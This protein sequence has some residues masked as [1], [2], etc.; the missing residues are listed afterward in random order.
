MKQSNRVIAISAFLMLAISSTVMQTVADP[1]K[2]G[3][4]ITKEEQDLH[5]EKMKTMTAEE[6]VQYRNEQYE[7]LRKKAA[8]IGYTMPDT[9]PWSESEKTQPKQQAKAEEPQKT[10][11]KRNARANEIPVESRHMRQLEKYRKAAAEKRKAMH[12]RLE[13]QRQSVKERIARLVEQNAVKSAPEQPRY[14]PPA[15][16]PAPPPP[17]PP[18]AY[19]GYYMPPQ[20]WRPGPYY[21]GYY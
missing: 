13:K 7:I 18:P 16:T 4:L 20:Q 17:P 2:P 8:N 15:Y 6:K 19:P 21:P 9:P 14:A 5:I 3:V 11:A 1:A 10:T 12:E